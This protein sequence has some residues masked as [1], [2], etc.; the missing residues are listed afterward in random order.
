MDSVGAKLGL[1]LKSGQVYPVTTIMRGL[2]PR[3][4]VSLADARLVGLESGV[5]SDRLM[6][7]A[8]ISAGEDSGKALVGHLARAD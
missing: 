3:W 1:D 8:L 4:L 6:E 5:K 7:S 2:F